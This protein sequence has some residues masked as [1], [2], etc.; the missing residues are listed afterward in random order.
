MAILFKL[1]DG[2]RTQYHLT[3]ES[4]LMGII[5]QIKPENYVT[6]ESHLLEITRRMCAKFEVNYIY[7]VKDKETGQNTYHGKTRKFINVLNAIKF[8]RKVNQ[9]VTYLGVQ[10]IDW[11]IDRE[12]I[13]F[14]T[15][16][17]EYKLM[18]G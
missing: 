4:A 5:A 9:D 16:T 6:T 2:E 12:V 7:K 10:W 18:E 8:L 15:F 1:N 13:V 17:R 11:G 3:A 14:G